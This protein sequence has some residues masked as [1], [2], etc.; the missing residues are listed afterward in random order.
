MFLS[1]GPGRR[2][3]AF[4]ILGRGVADLEMCLWVVDAEI[5][6]PQ[7]GDLPGCSTNRFALLS[8][9]GMDPGVLAREAPHEVGHLLGLEHCIKDCVMNPSNNREEARKK[10]S[11]LCLSCSARLR[12]TADLRDF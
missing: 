4:E 6:Y 5:F 8:R 9:A 11:S 2:L 7:T 12:D 1:K 3:Q 10:P